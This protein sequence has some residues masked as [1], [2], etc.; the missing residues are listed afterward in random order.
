MLFIGTSNQKT[1]NGR[2]IRIT[3]N[4][5]DMKNIII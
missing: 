3:S 5:I 4:F 1:I 2:D